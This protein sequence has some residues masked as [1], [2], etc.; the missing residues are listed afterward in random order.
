MPFFLSSI[1][2]ARARVSGSESGSG[3]GYRSEQGS[4]DVPGPAIDLLLYS[5]ELE[6]TVHLMINI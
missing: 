3:P 4:S 2:L 5:V 6:W 1:A